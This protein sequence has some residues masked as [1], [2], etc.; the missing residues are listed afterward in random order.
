MSE[1]HFRKPTIQEWNALKAL[2]DL[3]NP[4]IHRNYM[5]GKSRAEVKAEFGDSFSD[6]IW[7]A[8]EKILPQRFL[9]GY[10]PEHEKT[11]ISDEAA[12]QVDEDVRHDLEVMNDIWRENNR[13]L[14]PLEKRD[15]QHDLEIINEM[16]PDHNS[17]PSKGRDVDMDL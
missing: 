14:S 1:K 7:T 11:P 12:K 3:Q 15:V 9:L 10:I 8:Y 5:Q 6:K 13:E 17:A 2:E 16:F 4:F